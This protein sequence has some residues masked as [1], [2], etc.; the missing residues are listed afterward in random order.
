M[1]FKIDVLIFHAE[2]DNHA[3]G[4]HEA[5]WVSNFQKFLN[6]LLK[7]LLGESQNIMLKS[8]YD[9]ITAADI[10]NTAVI[11]PVLSTSFMS[12][13]TIDPLMMYFMDAAEDNNVNRVFKVLKQPIKR[14]HQPET[15]RDL[16]P[17]ELY[18]HNPLT[19][20]ISE[21]RDFFSEEAEQ[22]FWM[23]MVDLSY[24]IYE[25]LAVL[26][27]KAEKADI[28][29]ICNRKKTIYLAETGPD[30]TVQRKIIKRE[31]LRYGCKIL[32]DQAL[33]DNV[34][35]LKRSMWKDLEKADL[36]IHLIGNSYATIPA[37]ATNS[38][39]EIQNKLSL[40]FSNLIGSELKRLVW[41]PSDLSLAN[42]KQQAFIEKLKRDND[43]TDSGDIFQISL[44]DFKNII[45]EELLI[46]KQQKKKLILLT[47]EELINEQP[48]VYVIY[49]KVDEDA[50][51]PI[52]E[53]IKEAGYTLLT[54]IF[55]GELLDLRQAHINNL[56]QFD[57]AI[58][59][60][61]K[62]N[63]KWVKMKILDLIKAPGFGRHKPI[64]GRI[65]ISE[66]KAELEEEFRK[67]N[68]SMINGEEEDKI[69]SLK[70]FLKNL[71]P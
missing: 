62:V 63:D 30:L 11:I 32:P 48:S 22:D 10:E 43:F 18:Y 34:D 1:S 71:T 9:T 6:L 37:G 45:R 33:P 12:S 46:S 44:E 38:I 21:Y 49:D 51:Q 66:K 25:S 31:L 20:E 39:V 29:S 8:E 64:K 53:L 2:K 16:L 17:Y 41:I 47:K 50:A 42:D 70:E 65:L 67:Y 28:K 59:Y 15:V 7:Q 68:I 35:E 3:Q 54:P 55:E 52:K 40:S 27:N 58:I 24:D 57:A 5:G 23:K 69:D 14:D 36:C 13:K 4:K 61:N 26:Q 60:Q 19:Y 56:Q